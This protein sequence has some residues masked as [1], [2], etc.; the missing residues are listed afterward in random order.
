MESQ[1]ERLSR[2][3]TEAENLL[4]EWEPTRPRTLPDNI[5]EEHLNI[6]WALVDGLTGR[7]IQKYLTGECSLAVTLQDP[8]WIEDT[9]DTIETSLIAARGQLQQA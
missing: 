6:L 4:Y 1:Q 5:S 8:E 7:R 3:Y 2:L 9:L